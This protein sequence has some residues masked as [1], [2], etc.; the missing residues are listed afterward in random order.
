[1][2][3]RSSDDIRA[4]FIKFWQ[5]KGSH[6]Q[7]SSSLIPHN[8]PTVLLTTAGMQQF[9]PYFLGKERSPY[10]R[11]VSV[12]KC[13]RTS[14]IDE[15]GDRSHQT[16]FEMLGNFSVGDYFKAEVIPWALEFST[17]HLG[18]DQDRLW[19][20]IHETDD[21][22]NQIWLDAGIPQERIKR[23]GDKENWWGPPGASGP[24]GPNSELYYAQPGFACG[25]PGDP[26]GCDCGRLEYWNLVFMQ[27]NQD[28]AG[29]RTPLPQPNVDTGMGMERVSVVTAGLESTYDTDLFQPILR[30][31]ERITGAMYGKEWDTD[32]A[33]R[34][35]ADHARAMTFLVLDG[36]VPGPG[37][38][39]YVLRRIVRRAIRY[40]RRLGV[41]RAFL[42]EMLDAVI[43]RMATHYPDLTTEASRIKQVLVTEEEIFSRTLQSGSAQVDRLIAEARSG[44]VSGKDVFDLY[45]TYGFPVEL[46]EEILHEAGLSFDREGYERELEAQRQRDREGATQRAHDA[47]DTEFGALPATE[48]LAWTA[49]EGDARVLAL[50]GA[51]S[52]ARLV[53]EASPFYPNGGGQ[54]GD[55]GVIRTPTGTF[56]VEDTRN[57]AAGHIVHYGHFEGVLHPGEQAHAEVDRVRRDRS[58]RHHTATHL[59][60]RALKDVLGPGTSQQ[61]SYVGPDLLRFDFNY[62]RALD[63]K[64]LQEVAD[65]INARGM[66]NLEVD[67]QI[68]P[69]QQATQQGAI[70]MFGEK[71]GDQVR[72][73]SIG[74]YS[75]ELCGGTHTHRSGDL[76]AVSIA[77]ESGIGSGRR[78][79]VAYA[80]PAAMQYLNQRLQLLETLSQKVGARNPEEAASRLDALLEEMEGLR[81]DLQRRQ[82]QQATNQAGQLAN[83]AVSVAGVKVV[84]ATIDGA[85]GDD[86]ARLVDSIRQELRSGVVVLAG[87]Q[88]GRIP[89]VVGVTRDLTDRLHAGN[90][91]GAVAKAVDGGG[92]GNNAEFARGQGTNPAKI[93]AALQ[94]AYTLVEQALEHQY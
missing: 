37:G 57:D 59:L 44:T 38:R 54:V 68:M 70:A 89:L 52:E 43:Q 61:G 21:E 58:R 31:A 13:F 3:P 11:Y 36:V 33:L 87:S 71:Y 76:G 16:F 72:V 19:I 41:E 55:T 18:L 84:A 27:Y 6:L 7:P 48:F 67:W 39:D 49:T 32:Y 77:S 9:V 91:V 8:D 34:V 63:H 62:P 69:I 23:F 1:M 79:I 86:L 45:Q 82:Q 22:A 14:D 42:G 47:A 90:I 66:D 92:G 78:R 12:Q 83:S 10:P 35:L 80:G 26:V 25:F 81:K 15:V 5:D 30:A 29:L 75:R 40:G 93:G 73:V 46:T 94:H 85:S 50:A 65:I 88:N 20:T 28:E 56:V 53:L 51:P 4:A 60:H 17:K 74:D 2:P 64:Q 24:C